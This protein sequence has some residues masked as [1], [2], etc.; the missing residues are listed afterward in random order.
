MKKLICFYLKTYL[1]YYLMNNNIK[2]SIDNGILS[3]QIC[4]T[5]FILDQEQIVHIM[6]NT[7]KK[8]IMNDNSKY[9]YFNNSETNKKTTLLHFLY[10]N[11]NKYKFKNN[12][13]YDLKVDNVIIMDI[14]NEYH[15]VICNNYN[16]IDC[17]IGHYRQDKY[18][19]PYWKC[20]NLNFIILCSE[21]ILFELTEEQFKKILEYEEFID[22][23]L[24][25]TYLFHKNSR[26][27]YTRYKTD[28]ININHIIE[29]FNINNIKYIE[30]NNIIDFT[31][32]K[33][34]HVFLTTHNL[35][36]CIKIEKKNKERM[37]YMDNL[38]KEKYNLLKI[39]KG[40]IR[41]IGRD[42]F[43]EKNRMWKTYDEEENKN[44]YLMYCEPND[45]IILCKK[46]IN[47]IKE[48]EKNNT[49]KI[50]WHRHVNGYVQGSNNLYI[51]Q[52]I[53]GCHGNGQGTMDKS[54]DHIDRDPLNN[55]FDNLKIATR[56]EQQENTKSADGERKARSKSA[57]PL[58]D[59]ITNDMMKKYIV[60]YKECYNKEKNLYREFFKIE[61]HPKLEKPW[62]GSKSNKIS[63]IDKLTEANNQFDLLS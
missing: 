32:D 13:I 30:N 1:Y 63:I 31:N 57:K 25:W 19:N 26:N 50:T 28:K 47:K 27:I 15:D 4:N 52:V 9:P 10:D 48:F 44:I 60:Y 45:F 8:W 7:T 53:T 29:D 20:E 36:D 42:A 33:A 11:K 6:N 49:G 54:V 51:H 46:S 12:N 58:P 18:F 21:N 55:C 40:H 43:M 14:K 41:N 22:F 2:V 34:R 38:V 23:K 3:L 5:D 16:I 17:N 61:K 56:K 35:E 37:N 24:T 59:G 39:Y 62:I